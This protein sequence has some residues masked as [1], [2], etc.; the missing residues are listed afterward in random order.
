[1]EQALL[2]LERGLPSLQELCDAGIFDE[3]RIRQII[4]DRHK[5]EARLKRRPALLEDFRAYIE[6]EKTLEME[7]RDRLV[8]LNLRNNQRS[9]QHLIVTHILAVYQRALAKFPGDTSLWMELLEYCQL[10]D[11]KAIFAKTMAKALQLHPRHVPFWI[12]AATHEWQYN[13]NMTAARTYFQKGL[14]LNADASELW[15]AFFTLECDFVTKLR[16]RR[17]ALGLGDK[18][19][20]DLEAA[21][22]GEEEKVIVPLEDTI[23]EKGNDDAESMTILSGAIALVV[24]EHALESKVRFTPEQACRICKASR[25]IPSMAEKTASCLRERYAKSPQHVAALRELE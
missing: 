12:K 9:G 3:T 13:G 8:P 5:Y 19:E 1:M 7:R 6:H 17:E 24:L 25:M 15:V 4:K 23:P 21:K 11:R 18:A 10:E 14:R 16:E 20:E 2:H 22:E